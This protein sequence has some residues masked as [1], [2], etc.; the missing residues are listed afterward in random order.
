MDQH[1][2]SGNTQNGIEDFKPAASTPKI[3]TMKIERG[4]VKA[5]SIPP[6]SFSVS[7]VVLA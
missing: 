4:S 7:S 1:H 6:S 5:S 3:K 2:L